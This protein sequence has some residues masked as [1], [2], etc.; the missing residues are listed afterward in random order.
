MAEPIYNLTCKGKILH[1]GTV[2][3]CIVELMGIVGEHTSLA[4]VLARGWKLEHM[5]E[6]RTH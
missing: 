4:S 1:T 2:H 6:R 3:E 5:P